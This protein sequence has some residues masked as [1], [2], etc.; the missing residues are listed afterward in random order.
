VYPAWLLLSLLTILAELLVP[1]L[2]H[3]VGGGGEIGWPS[4][5]LRMAGLG[6]GDRRRGFPY[7][8]PVCRRRGVVSI[9]GIGSGIMDPNPTREQP[10][11]TGLFIGRCR[12][13]DLVGIWSVLLRHQG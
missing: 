12:H 1:H 9:A 10:V 5:E 6:H 11:S 4:A 13:R 3:L 2:V 8:R 7:A